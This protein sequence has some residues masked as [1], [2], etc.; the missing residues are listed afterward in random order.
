M[1][2]SGIPREH[3]QR[4]RRRGSVKVPTPAQKTHIVSA[5]QSDVRLVCGAWS[6]ALEEAAAHGFG[7]SHD[8]DAPVV[9]SGGVSDPTGTRAMREDLALDWLTRTR[10]ELA[11]LLRITPQL[12]A[13]GPFDPPRL[14]DPLCRAVADVVELWPLNTHDLLNRLSRLAFEAAKNWPPKPRP[15]EVIDGVRVGS[16]GP[17]VETCTE[18]RQPIGG[19]AADPLARIDNKPYHRT[20]CYQTVWQ[21]TRRRRVSDDSAPM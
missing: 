7:Q 2:N 5:A 16:R 6:G 9:S 3:T 4:H 12:G 10:R 13:S 19:G 11:G 18:C 20:P 8:P 14:T 17:T 21:R 15:G 1:V